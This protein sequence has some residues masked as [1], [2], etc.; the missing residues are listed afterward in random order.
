MGDG[1]AG[2]AN[3]APYGAAYAAY[4]PSRSTTTTT[5]QNRHSAVS[6]DQLPRHPT[7][8]DSSLVSPMTDT[9]ELGNEGG[10]AEID[11]HAVMSHQS[12]PVYEMPTSQHR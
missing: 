1:R 8:G 6:G 9:A 5:Q 4:T 7:P 11:G 3:P 10:A 2:Y 12:G